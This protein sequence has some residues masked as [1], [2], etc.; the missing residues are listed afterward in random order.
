MLLENLNL[1][2]ILKRWLLNEFDMYYINTEVFHVFLAAGLQ[3]SKL[4]EFRA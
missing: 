2:E 4:L 3:L 1:M